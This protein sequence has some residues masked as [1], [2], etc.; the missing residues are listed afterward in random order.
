MDPALKPTQRKSAVEAEG[1]DENEQHHK[2]GGRQKGT[3]GTYLPA[4]AKR[5]RTVH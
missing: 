5:V 1:G 3:A 2:L 4:D